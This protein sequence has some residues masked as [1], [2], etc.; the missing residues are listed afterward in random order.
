MKD[1]R[2]TPWESFVAENNRALYNVYM[3]TGIKTVL[4]GG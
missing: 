1:S 2:G 3:V 4:Y